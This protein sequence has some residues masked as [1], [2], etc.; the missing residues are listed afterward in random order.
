MAICLL[1]FYRKHILKDIRPYSC[2]FLDCPDSE[3]T[4]SS[5][6][7]WQNHEWEFHRPQKLP[8]W[9][10]RACSEERSFGDKTEIRKHIVD[11]HLGGDD[12][13]D[14]TDIITRFQVE[15]SVVGERQKIQCPFCSDIVLEIR[16][17][18]QSHIGQHM[19]EI[20]LK[21][22]PQGE[23][24][25]DDD[26]DSMDNEDS[27]SNRGS[28]DDEHLRDHRLDLDPDELSLIHI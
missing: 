21:A 25:T 28:S 4:F 8:L 12:S 10:C 13:V 26:E 23:Y 14:L 22:L 5:R 16:S 9:K 11:D 1:R 6:K 18:I 19:D 7:E 27:H 20:A 3:T 15:G 2:L 24:S 17:V